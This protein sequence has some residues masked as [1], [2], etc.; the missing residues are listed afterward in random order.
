MHAYQG[1]RTAV[2]V[3]YSNFIMCSE[4]ASCFEKKILLKVFINM[5]LHDLRLN[6]F[7]VMVGK[8]LRS[9]QFG[10]HFNEIRYGNFVQS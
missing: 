10:P 8:H 3:G 9:H 1:Y 2:P 4:K 5:F 6:I 7:I